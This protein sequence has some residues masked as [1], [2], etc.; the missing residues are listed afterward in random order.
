MTLDPFGRVKPR[1]CRRGE[2]ARL[3]VNPEQAPAF[4]PGSRRVDYYLAKRPYPG[5]KESECGDIGRIK[6]F[7]QE[8]VLIAMGDVLGHGKDAHR[9]ASISKR[10]LQKNYRKSLI[11]IVEG[12]HAHIRSSR[13]EVLAVCLLDL[14]TGELK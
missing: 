7:G 3:R 11:D 8:K 4:R 9:L 5:H 12:L 14:N 13:G 10:Y 1:L 2:G 6:E